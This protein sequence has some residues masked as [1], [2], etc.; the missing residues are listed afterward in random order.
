MSVLDKLTKED[1]FMSE[2][3]ALEWAEWERKTIL[4]DMKKEGKKEGKEEGKEEATIGLIKSM[5]E[6]NADLEFISKVT[7][8][9][10]EEI[11]K[12]LEK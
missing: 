9:S 4:S 10:K 12:I 6:N 8:K 5:L 7:G 2:E 11:E 3:E 1:L